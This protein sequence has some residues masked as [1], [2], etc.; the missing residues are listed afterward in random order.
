MPIPT[1]EQRGEQ[2]PLA[3]TFLIFRSETRVATFLASYTCTVGALINLNFMI[4][5]I[6]LDYSNR[7][8]QVK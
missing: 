1:L 2:P 6:N 8:Q 7:Y 5:T 3:Y 4:K